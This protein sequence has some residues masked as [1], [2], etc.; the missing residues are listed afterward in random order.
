MGL[1]QLEKLPD[2]PN[3]QLAIESGETLAPLPNIVEYPSVLKEPTYPDISHISYERASIDGY[4]DPV[5]ETDF[6]KSYFM[7]SPIGG[8]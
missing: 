5:K 3:A 8:Y 4:A 6:P 1:K 7:G 2:I